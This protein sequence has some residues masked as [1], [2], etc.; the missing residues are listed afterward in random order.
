MAAYDAHHRITILIHGRIV[1]TVS[2]LA[3]YHFASLRDDWARSGSANP[4]IKV[5]IGA[6]ASADAAGEGYVDIGTLENYATN[7]QDTF[8]SFGG[9]MLWDASEAYSA[10]SMFQSSLYMLIT[11]LP[12]NHRYD[13]AIKNAMTANAARREAEER[14]SKGHLESTYPAEKPFLHVQL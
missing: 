7:G 13:K 2:E 6:A 10:H 5:Y 9:V 4:D 1:E 11:V 12:A 8:D 3:T 14:K